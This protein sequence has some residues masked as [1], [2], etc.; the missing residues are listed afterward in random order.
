MDE[1]GKSWVW[2]THWQSGPWCSWTCL[3]ISCP[4]KLCKNLSS[5]QQ[6]ANIA[7]SR[8]S[9]ITILGRQCRWL[10]CLDLN[11]FV[12]CW[13]DS[14]NLLTMAK[15]YHLSSGSSSQHLLL[16]FLFLHLYRSETHMLVQGLEPKTMYEF[17]V[18]LHV[19]QLSSP[20]S[21]V[22]YHTTLPEGKGTRQRLQCSEKKLVSQIT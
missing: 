1:R 5:H 7:C 12:L 3:C 21:P 14:S 8:V 10:T 13:T 18:R 16:C 15:R 19:D 2:D 11:W 9:R 17:A 4:T 6:I 22:V 20:W